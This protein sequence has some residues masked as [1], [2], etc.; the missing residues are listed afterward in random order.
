MNH[1]HSLLAMSCLATAL[2]AIFLTYLVCQLAG[3]NRRWRSEAKAIAKFEAGGG[4]VLYL[5]DVEGRKV[6]DLI[7]LFT[8]NRRV[9]RIAA[10]CFAG[11]CDDRTL[12]DVCSAAGLRVTLVRI[13]DCAVSDDGLLHLRRLAHLNTVQ[14]Y[15]SQLTDSCVESLLSIER[16]TGLELHGPQFTDACTNAIADLRRLESLSV[17]DSQ[18]SDCGVADISTMS[19]VKWLDLSCTQVSDRIVVYLK[20]SIGLKGIWLFNTPVSENGAEQ[21]RA[22]LPGC[23]VNWEEGDRH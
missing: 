1:Q 3:Y 5:H 10:V 14:L 11:Q 7:A 12:R 4:S 6:I 19:S 9:E 13:E 20:H 15:G 21:L 2:G 17:A 18:I 8:A 23:E 16:L 22:V